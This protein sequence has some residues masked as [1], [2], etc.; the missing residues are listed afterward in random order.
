[1]A[2][3]RFVKKDCTIRLR[4]AAAIATGAKFPAQT[5]GGA[6]A[7]YIVRYFLDDMVSASV[8]LG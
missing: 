1:M 5:A 2:S 7:F 4:F 3:N 8:A 6:V